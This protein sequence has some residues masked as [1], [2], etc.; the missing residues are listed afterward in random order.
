MKPEVKKLILLNLPY[1][2]FVYLF[3]KVGQAFRLAQGIDLS[4]KLLHIGQ[5]FTAAF[6]SAAPSFHP[7][8]LLIGIAGAVII[9]LVVYSKQKNAKKYR[10]G[11]EYG[12]ARW[13]TPADIKPFIDPVF[14][15]NVLLTQ[16]ERLMMSNRPKDPKNARNKNILVIGG[17]GSGKTRFFAKPNIMQLH[18]SYVITDPKGSLISEVGQLLQRAKYRIKVLNTINFSKSMHYNPFA[19]LRSEKDILKLVNTIIVNTK[20]EGAQSAED[21]WVKSERLFYSALIGYI[22]YEAPEEEKNFTT[23][24]DM[25]NA[26]EAKEDDSEFQSPVDLMFARLEEKDPEHFAVRQYKKFLLSA[27]KTRASIL[28]SCGARLAPFDIR[29]LRELM[30]YDEMELDTL[31]DRKTALFLIMSDTDSTFNFVIAILQSQLFNLLCDK[32]DDV[33]GGRL[34][35]HVRCILDEFANIGQIPQFDKLIATIRSREI[36]ASIILQSQSQLKAIY[37]DNADTIVGNCD[38]MLFLGGKEKTTL[39]EISEILGKETI[40]SFNTSENRGKEISHGLNYQKLGK[41]LMTQDEIATMDGG[42]C[43]LQVRGIRPFFSKKY[44]I[45]KHPNYKYLSDADKKNAFDVERYIRAQ[46]KKKRTPA[47]V[48]PEEPFDFYDIDLSDMNMAAEESGE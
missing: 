11:M 46:R 38:T 6:A 32:A 22:F 19:Y 1:L 41:E 35:V 30:E 5:G 36:S 40:D 27:G 20:G 29:E 25:I 47:V 9:R 3:G 2:L 28:V 39:K 33:Y 24:L 34:P 13:G 26:S 12:T 15:N 31:G 4:A 18:S 45:T 37:R 43:I 21:F 7:V 42:M 48:E 44:D 23:M 14:E 8:D 16:T 17:S 10:K